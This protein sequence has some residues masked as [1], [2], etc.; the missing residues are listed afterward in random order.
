MPLLH[1]A[2]GVSL[3]WFGAAAFEPPHSWPSHSV[4][5]PASA[6]SDLSKVTDQVI[7]Q[8]L[9]EPIKSL[10]DYDLFS[11]GDL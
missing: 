8:F 3:S 5:A 10:I 11:L 1:L 2:L 9:V 6:L 7:T 4:S